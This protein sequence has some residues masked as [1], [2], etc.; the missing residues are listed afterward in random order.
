MAKFSLNNISL[1]LGPQASF[2]LS[3]RKMLILKNLKHLNLVQQL[4]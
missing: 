3:E 2:L 1:D 4:V